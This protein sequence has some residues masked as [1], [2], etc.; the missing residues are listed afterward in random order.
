[1]GTSETAGN[2]CILLQVERTDS[3]HRVVVGRGLWDRLD[4][5]PMLDDLTAFE[6]EDVNHSLAALAG[7]TNPIA[8]HDDEV[9]VGEDAFEVHVRTGVIIAN[10]KNEFAHPVESVFNDRIMLAVIPASVLCY[11]P[12][13]IE[14]I[15]SLLKKG[16]CDLLVLFRHSASS[17]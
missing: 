12:S 17:C 2:T 6:T 4:H 11:C 10:P 14:L 13:G 8:V 15:E 3:K 7:H 5:V 16:E 1:L 9:S